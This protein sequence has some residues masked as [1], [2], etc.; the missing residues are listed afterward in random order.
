MDVVTEKLAEVPEEEETWRKTV[1]S[2]G[3]KCL[4]ASYIHSKEQA[5]SPSEQEQSVQERLGK[6]LLRPSDVS[7]SEWN[8]FVKNGLK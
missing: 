5:S 6:V 4:A 7:A 3:L 2:T 8:S 1:A